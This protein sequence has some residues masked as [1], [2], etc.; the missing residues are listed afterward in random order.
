MASQSGMRV[1]WVCNVVLPEIARQMEGGE[2][3]SI[4]GW[5]DS[6]WKAVRSQPDLTLGICF[7]LR[8]GQRKQKG[9]CAGA[10]YY[11]F[12]QDRLVYE[13]YDGQLE[14]QFREI[15]ADFKPDILHV[16]GTEY[17][18]TLAAV[19]AFDKRERT[20]I[21][22]Q[23]MVSIYAEHFMAGVPR[24][25]QTGS[26]F[27]DLVKRDNLLRQRAGFLKRGV[28]ER[29]A[30]QRAGHIIGRTDWDKACTR[31]IQPDGVYH[32]CNETL[33][34]S[35]YEGRWELE[36]CERHSIFASQGSYPIKGFHYLLKAAP[37]L[38]RWYPDLKIYVA[39][40]D[41]TRAQSLKDRLRMTSYGKYVRQLIEENKLAEK[42]IYTGFLDERA[43]RDRYLKSH[44]FVS[45]SSIEN[46][47]NS[48][49]EAMLLGMP[50]VASDV[51]GVKNLMTHEKEGY[52]YQADAP[53]MLAYYIGKIFDDDDLAR[54]LG[55]QAHGRAAKTHDRQAN[56]SR[57]MEIYGEILEG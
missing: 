43:M 25:V 29:E 24:W 20:V 28:F 19:R 3:P 32:F 27:R 33:R 56:A 16:F 10:V 1:L 54:C 2:A 36:N 48:V 15:L 31:Q 47:P 42:V 44:V 7:P 21:S 22:I 34:D 52:V 9:E 45:P 40:G 35:F 17:V 5:M 55:S 37:I 39:G 14:E 38:L 57:L 49:G 26:T 6:I 30:V 4:G 8:P 41:I 46:S 50:V 23:G 11:G 13:A 51:G 53:Y 12:A 18:H